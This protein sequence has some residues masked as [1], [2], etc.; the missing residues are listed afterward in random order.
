MTYN[1]DCLTDNSPYA[2]NINN[3]NKLFL[4]VPINSKNEKK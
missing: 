2:S 4:A 1:I 3:I